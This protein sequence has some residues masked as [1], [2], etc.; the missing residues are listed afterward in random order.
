MSCGRV[1]NGEA[2]TDHR[3]ITDR[4]IARTEPDRAHI[5]ITFAVPVKDNGAYDICDKSRETNCSHDDGSWY[6]A[7][8]CVIDG[9][10]NDPE[11]EDPHG[12]TFEEGCG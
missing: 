9:I 7:Q 12:G 5:C 2:G 11:T 4:V 8:H 3:N 10:A 1:T 6:G